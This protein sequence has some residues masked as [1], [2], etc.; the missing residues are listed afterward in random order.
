[1]AEA[2]LRKA[3]SSRAAVD[4]RDA[5]R[6]GRAARRRDAGMGRRRV[7]ARAGQL[8]RGVRGVSG[9]AHRRVAVPNALVGRGDSGN[10]TRRAYRNSS[11]RVGISTRVGCPVL[12]VGSLLLTGERRSRSSRASFVMKRLGLAITWRAL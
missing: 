1:M 10:G 7:S 3:G 11:C 12:C 9:R 8:R 5:L 4:A 2:A 6:V